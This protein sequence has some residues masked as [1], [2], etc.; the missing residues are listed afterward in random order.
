MLCASLALASC[1][2]PRAL[3]LPDDGALFSQSYP[4][5]KKHH[6]TLYRLRTGRRL[7]SDSES[8]IRQKV[9]A[10]AIKMNVPESILGCTLFLQSGLNH[11]D[12]VSGNKPARGLGQFL[13]FDVTTLNSKPGRYSNQHTKWLSQETGAAESRIVL[14]SHDTQRAI[15]YFNPSTAVTTTALVLRD[16]FTQ[17]QTSL[18]ANTIRYDADLVWLLSGIAY[19]RSPR[20]ILSLWNQIQ[21]D[22]GRGGLEEA[23]KNRSHFKQ[24]FSDSALV[25]KVLARTW[26]S[27]VALM[28]ESG[29]IDYLHNFSDCAVRNSSQ[30]ASNLTHRGRSL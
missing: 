9:S 18:D 30:Q 27:R 21:K 4:A 15:S 20:L 28:L 17:L 10:L 13:S 29:Y 2:K 5:D 6:Q 22:N 1:A 7:S 12:G 3:P 11:L 14:D 23:L 26:T 8:M 25:R 24:V 19:S 16:R